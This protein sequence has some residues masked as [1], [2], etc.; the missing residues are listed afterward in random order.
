V[1]ILL[2]AAVAGAWA[3]QL[4]YKDPADAIRWHHTD[5]TLNGKFTTK[6]GGETIPTTGSITFTSR[7]RV[8]AVNAD[9]T[10]TIVSDITDGELNMKVGDQEMSQPLTGYKS[11][12]KRAPSGKVTEMKIEGEPKGG[13]ADLQTMG[14]SS[15]WHMISG[16]GQ[17]FEFSPKDMK[18]GAKWRNTGVAGQAQL[19]I[20]NV[21]RDPKTVD[22]VSYL[23]IA[24]DTSVKIPDIEL[25][26]PVG[27]DS[28]TVK[29]TSALTAKSTS[30]FDPA[31]GE[32]F[33]TDFTGE[34]KLTMTVPAP[35]QAVTVSGT[36]A[37]TGCTAKISEPK[38]PAE[39]EKP[40]STEEPVKTEEPAKE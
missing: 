18:V 21:L 4:A 20:N 19:T 5:I 2:L 26:I 22:G 6:P 38:E 40:V 3:Y 29:Q 11:V 9:G 16:L 37:L 14:F 36:I 8:I 31:K 7:E 32:F 1:L 24:G 30:L 17:G 25:P 34:L 13:L 12:F 35:D 23:T 15:Q 28:V 39:S 33:Q 10:A 27:D